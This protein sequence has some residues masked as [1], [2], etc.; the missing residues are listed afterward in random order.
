VIDLEKILVIAVGS[1]VLVNFVA[2]LAST[3][4]WRAVARLWRRRAKV[5]RV[6]WEQTDERD[7]GVMVWTGRAAYVWLLVAVAMIGW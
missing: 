3:I 4:N 6:T 2:A 7:R 1:L 5:L